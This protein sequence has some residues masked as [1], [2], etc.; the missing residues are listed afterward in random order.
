M[1]PNVLLDGGRGLPCVFTE[2]GL[3]HGQNQRNLRTVQMLDVIR[4]AM[5]TTQVEASEPLYGEGSATS[6]LRLRSIP[7][8]QQAV[9]AD[10]TSA[11]DGYSCEGAAPAP[12]AERVYRIRVDEAVPLEFNVYGPVEA[13]IFI[14]GETP[15]PTRCVSGGSED[16]QYILTPGVHHVVVEVDEADEGAALS[17]VIDAPVL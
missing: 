12:G 17:L 9:V 4:R 15:D 8:G 7:F 2:A 6:P 11:L 5:E 3:E 14:L 13:R 1:H 10:L 16:L